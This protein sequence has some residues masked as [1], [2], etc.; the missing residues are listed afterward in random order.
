MAGRASRRTIWAT[1]A[2][3]AVAL[4]LPPFV[5]VNRYRVR[6]A[7]SI[8]RALGRDVTVSN[9]E[10]KVL[11]RPGLVLSNFVV[12]EDASYGAEPMLRAESVTA[13][14]RLTSLWRGRLEIGTLDLDNP[15]LNLV[16]RTDRH[17]NLEELVQRA[18]QVASAPTN[19]KRPEA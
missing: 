9:I 19:E 12:A 15:S 16:R 10:L 14:L 4:L 13:Y 1:L 2:L 18:S 5:N 11:P 8:S 3:V 17:W 7:Q 6:V